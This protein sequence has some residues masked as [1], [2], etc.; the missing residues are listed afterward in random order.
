MSAA[1]H[2]G[3]GGM[4][5]ATHG[6]AVRRIALLIALLAF[7]RTARADEPHAEYR[8]G[9]RETP[10]VDVPFHLDLVIEG[11][12]E[13]P[14][15]EVPKL[16]IANATVAFVAA[17]PNVQRG[18]QIINGRRSDFAKVTWI[19]RWRIEPHKEGR[20]RVPA[21]T[22]TQG[23]KRATVEAAEADVDTIPTT[24]AMKL[25]LAL[26]DR[27]IFVGETVPV[28]LTWLF[29]SEP[30]GDIKWAIPLMTMDAFTVSGPPAK[31]A[32]K[33]LTFPA[34]AKELQLPYEVDQVD[35]GGV[36][37]NRL[38]AT[39]FLAPRK[40]G[41]LDVPASSVV[42]ALATG[43][44]DFFGN[45][46]TRLFR[47]S[48]VPR[49][50]E[51]RPLPETDKPNNFAGAVGEQFSI[52]VTTSRSVVKLGEPVEL[53]IR[54][55]S[56]QRLDTLALGKL[57]GE[58]G[59]PK[60]RFVVPGDPPTGEL[61]EDGKTKTFK[62]TAQVTGPAT[63][64]PAIAFSY[65]DP[66]RSTY[67]TI[68]SEPIA[69]SVAGSS[70]VGAGDVVAARPGPG[71][72]AGARTPGA[73]GTAGGPGVEL[74]GAL[75]D[76]ELALSSLGQE[77]DRPIDGAAL[78]L[79]VGLCYAI[80]LALLGARSWQLRTQGLRDEAA[81]VRAARRR[82]EE[83]LDR[84]GSVPAREVAGPLAAALRELA[85]LLGRTI[86][87]EGLVARLETESFS[88]G[89]ATVPLSTDLRSDAAGL[90]RRWTTEARAARRTRS[91]RGTPRAAVTIAAGLL[92]GALGLTARAQAVPAGHAASA[93]EDGR[94]AYQ[95]A[96]QLTGNPTARKAAFA[97]A[98]TGFGEAVRA[99]PDRPELLTDWGNA[100]LGAG[101][102]AT[103][104][105]AYRR[106][107]A[108]DGG[109][110]RARHNLA[111]L[112]GHRADAL[113]PATGGATD[114]LLF[115]HAWP[116]ARKL[117]VGS[118]AF[119]IAILLVVP[120]S[121]RRRRGLAGLALLPLAVWVAM[122]ASVV[123]EDRH[124]DDAV[125]MDDVVLRAADSAGAPAALSQPLPRGVEVTVIERRDAWTKV[126]LAGGA[127]GWVP[128][129]AV[130]RI[131][132]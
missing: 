25:S 111:W 93:L 76:A 28:T 77:D 43:R 124:P 45:A 123:F 23:Q 2:A 106:A 14:Q 22:V 31:G 62:V 107:L 71:A 69:L 36:Q 39:F 74:D 99:M 73:P 54:I 78:W 59:L 51:V 57:D 32:R 121:G 122:L 105:L 49:V 1:N 37:Y 90:L 67:Q 58:G 82:V 52:D 129:G 21:L 11:F 115:F 83:L 91:A 126:R 18:I 102:V 17:Q 98:A 130:E 89:A 132:R 24:D 68:H 128:A 26:P 42:A 7:A 10:H 20:M 56:N 80:P 15:P 65:F 9:D 6:G 119:A 120:W 108:I 8:L 104:T 66:A 63:E 44:A 13:T 81:E 70:V 3:G 97:R 30:Q 40:V 75:V 27:P 103:A 55:K 38:V 127:A 118:A 16:A 86:D 94:A 33:A 96:M 72:Q 4:S 100:A 113:R 116:R 41:K 110:P 29:R 5:P 50:L 35:Q 47:A 34:G 95:E 114:T 125:V 79:L 112:R 87:D 61:S 53:A 85:K 19:L 109:N 101:D 131:A 88:Q 92:A 46:P 12:D 48:D 117:I 84:S 60:D 64:V